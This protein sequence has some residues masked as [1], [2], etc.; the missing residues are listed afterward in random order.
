MLIKIKDIYVKKIIK[1]K[2]Q[3]L[4]CNITDFIMC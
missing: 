4:I 3:K 2:Y 1:I